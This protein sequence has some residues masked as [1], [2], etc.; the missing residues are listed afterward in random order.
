[1]DIKLAQYR[2]K[3]KREEFIA[4]SKEKVHSFLRWR[5]IFISEIDIDNSV[6]SKVLI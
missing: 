6:E 2:A 1:M 3:R 4:K 5:P